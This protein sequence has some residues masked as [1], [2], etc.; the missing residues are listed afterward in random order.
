MFL[1]VLADS[2]QVVRGLDAERAE[3][4]AVPDPGELEDLG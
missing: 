1:E 4:L 3:P 2:R